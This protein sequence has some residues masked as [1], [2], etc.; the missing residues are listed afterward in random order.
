MILHNTDVRLVD[1]SNSCQGRLEIMNPAGSYSQACDLD[2]NS[3]TVEVV[4]R[5][6]GCNPNGARRADA[7]K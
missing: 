3:G 2:V 7:S 6:L 1:G 4:C 5:Q